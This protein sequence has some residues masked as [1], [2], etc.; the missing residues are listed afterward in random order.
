MMIPQSE[1]PPAFDFIVYEPEGPGVGRYTRA[2]HLGPY[3]YAKV[4]FHWNLPATATFKINC[5][6]A[7][8]DKFLVARRKVIPVRTEYNGE[9]WAGRVFT[10]DVEGTPGQEVM[11]VTCVNN[12]YYLLTILA[13]VNTFFPPEFQIWITGKQNI[14]FGPLDWVFKYF[15]VLNTVRLDVPVYVKIPLRVNIPLPTIE[16]LTDLNELL[17]YVNGIDFI[18]AS[19][20]F[21]QLDELFRGPTETGEIGLTMDL[22]TREEEMGP[23][24][25]VFNTENLADM[26]SIIDITSDN[27][28]N[29]WKIPDL[30]DGGLIQTEMSEPG[31]IFHTHTKRDRK[32]GI[33][34]T[35]SGQIV[36]YKRAIAH[37][38]ASR[39]IVGGQAPDLMNTLVEFAANLAIQVIAGMITAAFGLPGV[40]AIAVGDLF[41][42]IFFAF[43]LFKDDELE[44]D[45]GRDG[46]K[47]VFTD[48]TTAWSLDAFSVGING[49]EK[50]SGDDSILI[51]AVAGGPAGRNWTYGA[52]VDAD[53][54]D[55]SHRRYRCGDEMT[56]HDRG[57]YLDNW[58]SAV[59]IEDPR[60]KDGQILEYVVLGWDG[61]LKN[62]WAQL[63]D[64]I[65]GFAGATRAL[66]VLGGG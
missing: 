31:Y 1:K 2:Q 3:M 16:D 29:I 48:N 57:T 6:H 44:D 13:W 46:F 39:A 23:S 65:K 15:V 33:W 62:D 61:R 43:Q 59:D 21:T 32:W 11:T 26:Q 55:V 12:L 35:D 5:K 36:S 7:M 18:V 4:G 47:E 56:F 9:P 54:N 37:A 20:R 19:A 8:W 66:A 42:N 64:R 14:M 22:W 38:T 52:D 41:D 51:Q 40:G 28:L 50:A 17:E 25:E 63:V 60:D 27:F 45:L 10:V 24:P 53:G 34:S 49:L 58:V 30:V